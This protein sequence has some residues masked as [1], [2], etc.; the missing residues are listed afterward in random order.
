M[1]GT[2]IGKLA[3][4]AAAAAAMVG[5]TH[6]AHAAT[7]YWDIDGGNP[8]AGGASPAGT[9]DTG[10]TANWTLDSTG[11]GAA[12]VWAA[13][14]DAVFSAGTDAVGPFAVTVS[15]TQSANSL[16]VEE[17]SVQLSAG[18]VDF[19]A[20]NGAINV[21][22]GASLSLTA[23]A[24]LNGTNG[25]TK[26]GAGTLTLGSAAQPYSRAAGAILS[27]TGGVVEFS[28]TGSAAGG[29]NVLG[30]NPGAA[31]ANALTIDG[32]TLR[33]NGSASHTLSVNRGVTIGANG[34]TIEVV[35]TNNT[36]LS[37]PSAASFTL[38]GSGTL[39]KTGGGRFTLNTTSNSFTGKYRVLAGTLNS[40]GDGRFGLIP[41]APVADYFFLDGG[42]LRSAVTSAATWNVNRGITLGAGGGTI[43]QPGAG[44]TILTDTLTLAMKITGNAGGNLTIGNTGPEGGGT[45]DGFVILTNTGN[46]YNGNTTVNTGLTLRVGAA[47]VIPDG[48][49]VTLG[50]AGAALDLGT[51]NL[52]ET[53]KGIAGTSTSSLV[54]VGT[55]T[56]TLDNPSGQSFAGIIHANAGGKVIKNG[57]GAQT[58]SG[59]SV[60]GTTGPCF[61]REFVL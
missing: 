5:F 45:A 33:W 40:A 24:T 37:L 49:V 47:G 2:S 15:G 16:T 52:N 61:N 26:S 46:D 39:T 27:I 6:G 43:F 17:G 60:S 58:L 54:T 44:A 23:G 32:G 10:T 11:A 57:S 1:K 35:P 48:S 41:A 21:A 3:I 4:A 53:I 38:N 28:S 31:R 13:G 7:K 30:V 19:G 50:G 42:A 25:L 22:G 29:D 36:G 51:N 20:V 56:L 59:S 34:G 9:W 14:D 55:A 12:D 18:Q 8:G